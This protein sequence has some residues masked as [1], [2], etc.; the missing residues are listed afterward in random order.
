MNIRGISTNVTAIVGGM[1]GHACGITK[2]CAHRTGAHLSWGN[3]EQH[4]IWRPALVC[5][6]FSR[7]S[8]FVA[9]GQE[10]AKCG[11]A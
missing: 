2:N 8:E 1:Q 5:N 11:Q 10:E 7:S 4:W 9:K 6:E 3:S